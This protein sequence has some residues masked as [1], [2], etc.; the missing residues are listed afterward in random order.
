MKKITS[1][2]IL[3]LAVAYNASA[4]DICG[5]SVSGNT[6][7]ILPQFQRHFAGIKYNYRAF[8]TEHPPLFAN[9]KKVVSNEYY[10]TAEAWGRFVPHKRV[11]LFAFV[12]THF[13]KKQEDGITTL[14]NGLGDASLIVNYILLN[15]ANDSADSDWKHAL[16]M[17]G[18]VKLPTGKNSF[19]ENN[20]NTIPQM[21]P[22]TGSVD[23]PLNIIYTLRYKS[24]G[25]NSEY[26]YRV[27]LANA[28]GYKF[29]DRFNATTRVFYWKKFEHY[30]FLPN[31]G[32]SYEHGAAD[33]K[34]G[35]LQDYTGGNVVLANAGM[36][37]YFN[38]FSVGLSAQQ[39][40]YQYLGENYIHAKTRF[41]TNFIYL[42]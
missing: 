16:Q 26:N 34:D 11:Q 32:I 37:F 6:F 35:V 3:L 10:H 21:Q 31:T 30:T 33:V 17:G 15:T 4:C 14:S 29:G 12:P 7:G 22:G 13:Y 42:F 23:F 36:D 9:S 24:F 41:S 19:A 39:P 27:N 18:G 8:R 2:I 28:Q 20:E 25:L 1:I 38:K 40:V 5:C